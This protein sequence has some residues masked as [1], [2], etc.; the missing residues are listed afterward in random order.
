MDTFFQ[1][2]SSFISSISSAPRRSVSLPEPRLPPKLAEGQTR[3]VKGR[4]EN[5]MRA[6][7]LNERLLGKSCCI[8]VSVVSDKNEGF[9]SIKYQLGWLTQRP[10][11]GRRVPEEGYLMPRNVNYS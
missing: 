2:E 10:R 11:K 9:G 3:V 8:N 1:N 4:H 6:G 7:R 5:G